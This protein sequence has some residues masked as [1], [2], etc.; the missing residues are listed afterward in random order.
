MIILKAP[1][2]VPVRKFKCGTCKCEYLA[3]AREVSIYE[4]YW[5]AICPICRTA[6][7]QSKNLTPEKLKEA[8]ILIEEDKIRRQRYSD[9]LKERVKVA[10]EEL[11]SDS[12]YQELKRMHLLGEV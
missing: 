4:D 3:E 1:E 9:E 7:Q 2:N 10:T 5:V 12:M 8:R 6:S 11:Q